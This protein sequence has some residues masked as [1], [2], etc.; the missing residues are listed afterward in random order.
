MTYTLEGLARWEVDLLA[1]H[2]DFRGKGIAA[3]LV[4]PI[5][6]TGKARGANFA[7]GLVEVENMAKPAHLCPLWI[8]PRG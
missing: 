6:K 5:T 7:R 2:P 1:V 4:S 3:Q 8:Y